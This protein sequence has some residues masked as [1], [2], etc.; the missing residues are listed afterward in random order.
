[1]VAKTAGVKPAE[2]VTTQLVQDERGWLRLTP[3]DDLVSKRTGCCRG[4][5]TISA[6]R[7]AAP[8]RSLGTRRPAVR[9]AATDNPMQTKGAGRSSHSTLTSPTQ[10]SRRRDLEGVVLARI[11][12]GCERTVQDGDCAADDGHSV[13]V[14]FNADES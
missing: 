7:F 12:G 6:E 4:R 13:A 14:Q 11:R 8:L 1:M 10:G 2:V 5:A 3:S 9:M